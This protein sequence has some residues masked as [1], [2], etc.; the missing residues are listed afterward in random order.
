MLELLSR[1]WPWYVAGP[2]I[3]L[4]VPTLL[5]VGG[6]MFGISSALRTVCAMVA[7]GKVEFFHFDWR[8]AGGWNLAFSLGILVGGFIAGFGLHSP[9][10]I[11]IS[12]RTRA[13]LA[14]LGIH[15]FRGLVPAELFSWESL[16]T[17]KGVLLLGVGGFLVGFGAAWAG[18]CTSGHGIMGLADF[19]LPSLVAVIGFF[20]GGLLTTRF[21]LPLI[22]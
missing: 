22:L 3:G 11:D 8:R 15:D 18:G 12:A 20:V 16:L 5:V 2:L 13:E 19:Q 14:A 4:M 7:P 17:V 6:K 21:L 9:E 10:A 1:P